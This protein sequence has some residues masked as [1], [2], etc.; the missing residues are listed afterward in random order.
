MMTRQ[1]K[2]FAPATI[3]NV[4]PGFDI[5]GLA[6]KN[7][8]DEILIK[9]TGKPGITIIN[10]SP[11]LLP[12]DPAANVCGVVLQAMLKH[13]NSNQGF[14]IQV[15]KKIMP[16]SGMGSSA[17]SA[18]ATVFGANELM[19]RP[20]SLTELVGFA[21]QGERLASGVPHAD[22]VGPAL[23]GG[24][25]LIRS[26]NPLD[27]IKLNFELE[28]WCAVVHPHIEVKTEDARKILQD[29]VPLRDAVKQWG[30]VAG[31][32]TGLFKKDLDLISRSLQDVIVEP[33]RAMLIPGFDAVKRAA[34]TA[35]ALGSSISGSGPSIFALASTE[36]NAQRVAQAME[37]AFFNQGIDCDTVVSPVS[38]QG[39]RITG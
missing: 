31:L 36:R 30:N 20:F 16:G 11:Y 18:A 12:S 4:G 7:P 17:A 37:H 27:I 3:A 34:L 10:R 9:M 22:N 6:L 33:V 13:L 21:A 15:L 1:I 8:G 19:S 2:V 14:E 5:L 26:Y 28:L 25:V 29:K 32:I 24:F 35:G 38:N 39:V 23:L